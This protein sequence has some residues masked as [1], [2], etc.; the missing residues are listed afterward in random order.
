[1]KLYI[2]DKEA[3]F[4]TDFD[5]NMTFKF[6]DTY[7]PA[8]IKTSYSKTI[9]L[10]DC[11]ENA[12]IFG[13]FKV[14]YLFDLFNDDGR[15]IEKGYCTLDKI[16]TVGTVKS[17]DVTLYGGLGDFF[18]NLKGDDS[19]PKSLADLYWGDITGMYPEDEKDRTIMVWNPNYVYNSWMNADSNHPI[20]DTFRAVPCVYDDEILQKDKTIIPAV[21]NGIFPSASAS[22]SAFQGRDG[23]RA[24]LVEAEENTCYAKQDFRADLMPL[25]IKYKSIIETCCKPYN[26][27]GYSV[28]LDPDFFNASNP[29]WTNMFLLKTL[30]TL[31]YDYLTK[32]GELSDFTGS[33]V[34][35]GNYQGVNS[36][37]TSTILRTTVS[38][39][40]W[41]L[42]GDG[43]RLDSNFSVVEGRIYFEIQPFIQINLDD[44]PSD[45]DREYNAYLTSEGYLQVS[46]NI[47]NQDTNET[48]SL[49]GVGYSAGTQF[50]ILHGDF[51][52][53]SRTLY[54]QDLYLPAVFKGV[55][56]LPSGWTNIKFSITIGNTRPSS[57]FTLHYQD[58]NFWGNYKWHTKTV[59]GDFKVPSRETYH[60]DLLQYWIDLMESMGTTWPLLLPDSFL[61]LKTDYSGDLSA[62][63]PLTFTKQDLLG[64]TKTPFEY[65]TWFTKMFNLRFYLE[66][67]TKKVSI[68]TADNFIKQ[69]EPYNIQDKICYDREYSKTRKIVDEG[70]LKFNLTPNKNVT[71]NKYYESVDEDLLDYIY[72]IT[73]I[74]GKGQKEYLSSG[75]KI[76]SK[77]RLRSALNLR[78]TGSLNY[79][80]FNQ[81]SP[82]TVTYISGSIVDPGQE[83]ITENLSLNY[84]QESQ[85]YDFLNLEDDINDTVVM[86]S[87]L[88][89]TPFQG[90][91]AIISLTSVD[92]VRLAEGPCYIGG[93]ASGVQG[94][95]GSLLGATYKYT[96]KIP[97]Y[98]LVPSLTNYDNG[99]SYSNVDFESLIVTGNIYDKYLKDFIE[100]IYSDPLVV[101]CYVRLNSPELRRLYWFDNN[102]WI[103]TEISNYNY[104]DEPVKCKFIRYRT[105]A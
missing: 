90:S 64:T 25:G 54:V 68:L 2:N 95:E 65:L 94:G 55:A 13:D 63:E 72:P 5:A 61:T 104:R 86:Y 87:G 66:P 17:Y 9:S 79:Y 11:K 39:E 60:T 58:K 81:G 102:Y 1:M 14:K 52:E 91:P 103:L 46:L 16:K 8:A 23:S 32:T 49:M 89:D 56:Y 26:N 34:G 88:K 41:I 57:G 67:G 12:E 83:Y 29:Y 24:L 82:Y 77:G 78:Q 48:R 69:L 15:V 44:F 35:V 50:P 92:M 96:Y 47:I 76:G 22:G 101:E 85:R 40:P 4:S 31:E 38:S 18:Y 59:R 28:T 80:G 7:N 43:V 62:F 19:N 100:K 27:G 33:I 10:P 53:A 51:P 84:V 36:T 45:I 70:F 21:A 20:Y 37:S 30:P 3:F 97:H 73:I 74:G 71:V 93:I 42:S 99:L 98:G 75:L 105:D 6:L